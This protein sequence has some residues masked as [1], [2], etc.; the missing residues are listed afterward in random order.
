LADLANMSR[1]GF[2]LVFKKKV[3]VTPMDYLKHWRM[4]IA[5]DLLKVGDEPLSAIASATGYGSES[6]FSAAFQK[7]FQ[8][9]PGAYRRCFSSR[10]G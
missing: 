2:A 4:Q 8:Y 10:P 3:G 7:I 5:C 6:A 1:S 9:R